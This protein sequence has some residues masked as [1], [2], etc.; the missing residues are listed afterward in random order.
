MR[1]GSTMRIFQEMKRSLTLTLIK[2]NVPLHHFSNTHT[3]QT[4]M[5]KALI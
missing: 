2:V 4:R 1:E 5:R 3:S